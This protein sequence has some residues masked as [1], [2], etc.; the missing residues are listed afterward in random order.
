MKKK[1]L[2]LGLSLLLFS[3]TMLACQ[4]P[5][6]NYYVINV[7]N[8]RSEML[9]NS[10]IVLEPTFTNLG[11]SASPK[12]KVE[13]T[14]NQQDVTSSTYDVSTKV[15]APK[16]IGTYKVLFT[17]LNDNGEVYTTKDG[18]TFTSTVTIDVVIQSFAP[19]DGSGP[20][21]SV[22]DDGVLTFGPSYK[23]AN[24]EKI[25][26]KQYKVTGVTFE[27]SYS[28][29]Y[30]LK[31]LG[32]DEK[33][34]DPALYFGWIRDR[35]ENNDDCFKLCTGNGAMATWI[36]S[37]DGSLADLSINKNQGWSSGGWFNAPGS[38]SNGP[39]VGDHTITFER[40]INQELNTASYGILFDGTPYTYLNIGSNY[41][42]VLTNVWVESNNTS[43][44][45]SVKEY[46][47][48]SDTT[49]PTVNLAFDN[50]FYVGDSINLK[51]RTQV[52]DDSVYASVLAPTYKVFDSKGNE[53]PVVS[54]TFT[55]TE[56]GTYTIKAE[57][58]DLAMN[59]ATAEATLVVEDVDL[60]S[61]VIDVSETSSIAMPDS[62]IIL[63]YTATKE[64]TNVPLSSIKAFKG[65]EDVTSSTIFKHTAKT[66]D[67]MSYDY[68]KAPAGNYK[69][70]FT[71]EDGT[72]KEKEINVSEANTTVYGFTYYDIGTLI[73]KNKFIVGKNTIIY[74]DNGA[75][76]A[77]TVKLGYGLKDIYDW[78]IEFDITDLSYTAQGKFF[79]TKNTLNSS[80]SSIG[81][82]DLTV[83]G[84]VKG[85]GS[86]D[87]WG[88]ECSILGTG[89]VS[90]QWR[91][92]WQDKTTEFMPDPND[93]SKG[94]GRP[95]DAYS[96]YATGTHHYK[97]ACSMDTNN[98]VTYKYYINNE[99]EVVHV[100]NKDHNDGNGLDFIQFSSHH[101]NGIVS[102]IKVY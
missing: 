96:Q 38:V 12:Y 78:T 95:A 8:I 94:C 79:I 2:L 93:S 4:Q 37:D 101:M 14:L 33:Y 11:E 20:D 29:T 54:G 52:N 24:G 13:I 3:Y 53:L 57:V 98:V 76:D 25:T 59:K 87:L 89:W 70:V 22:S 77:Q 86:A 73:Y 67:N 35:S 72:T 81:W 19:R 75:N 71:A 7:S 51:S 100:T 91:S 28:I 43:G 69:L 58:N 36:W 32:F 34:I 46:K 63:Y 66:V 92:N 31:D 26:S 50:T 18:T 5:I 40:Y 62:G 61:T 88:Y 39:V 48:I 47:E 44:S 6:E 82:E 15:F 74:L 85:D 97:I 60:T 9:V 27:G 1:N 83:G 56:K 84:N 99:L 30:N 55:P 16:E 41:T 102:D 45:I 68:F 17:V 90:Y 21:V 42:D 23:Q 65:N 80:G 49:A 64:N 10:T